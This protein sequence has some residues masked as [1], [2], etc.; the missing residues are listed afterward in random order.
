M[1]SAFLQALW[2]NPEG[3]LAAFTLPSARTLCANT[4]AELAAAVAPFVDAENVYIRATSLWTQPPAGKRADAAASYAM[5]GIWADI[6][7]KGPAHKSDELPPD[8]DA[9]LAI[10]NCTELA[11]SLIVHSGNAR[12]RLAR[13]LALATRASPLPSAE[14]T[15]TSPAVGSESEQRSPEAA[16]MP[17][18]DF[19]NS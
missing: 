16:A 18:W 19:N 17:L 6:D 11:P 4:T 15:P 5:P 12:A 1:T 8:I 7:I 13:P 10:A 14:G 3:V 2:P 9:A